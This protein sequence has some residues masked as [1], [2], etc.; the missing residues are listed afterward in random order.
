MPPTPSY[1]ARVDSWPR[2]TT[3]SKSSECRR[4]C[5]LAVDVDAQPHLLLPPARFRLPRLEAWVDASGVANRFHGV[6]VER[7]PCGD[8]GDHETHG[9]HG[10]S[11]RNQ[12]GELDRAD[13]VKQR[14]EPSGRG[15]AEEESDDDADAR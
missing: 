12:D 8:G 6:D 11:D 2:E 7:R 14:T 13:A 1:S 9:E 15:D 3:N 10:G 4:G 5:W